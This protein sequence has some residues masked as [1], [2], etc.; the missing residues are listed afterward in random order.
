MIIFISL[1]ICSTILFSHEIAKKRRN[2]CGPVFNHKY[3]APRKLPTVWYTTYIS[4]SPQSTILYERILF[5]FR[6]SCRAQYNLS[7]LPY[8][9]RLKSKHTRVR[10]ISQRAQ[11]SKHLL[12]ASTSGRQWISTLKPLC[13]GF[14]SWG[15]GKWQGNCW[16]CISL[17]LWWG[18]SSLQCTP[19]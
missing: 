8:I 9:D 19:V 10:I 18:Q 7:G 16:G 13:R 2:I 12:D 14:R 5:K 17:L 4:Y 1:R 11:S 15:I 6:I 3:F